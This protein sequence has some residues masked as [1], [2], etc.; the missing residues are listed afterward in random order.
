M[1][2]HPL[3]S[4]FLGVILWEEPGT[5]DTMTGAVSPVLRDVSLPLVFILQASLQDPY[6]SQPYR[7][8]HNPCY[9][10][11]GTKSERETVL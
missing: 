2:R 9:H 6:A 4:F 8:Y 7:G 3:G 10:S 11:L 1:S 5:G